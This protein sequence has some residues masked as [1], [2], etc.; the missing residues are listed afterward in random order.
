[1]I[2]NKIF[3]MQIMSNNY[4][5]YQKKFLVIPLINKK[6]YFYDIIEFVLITFF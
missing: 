4:Y 1:M 3:F 2:T 6:K 5:D